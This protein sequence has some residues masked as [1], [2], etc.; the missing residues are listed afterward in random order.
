[1]PA[2]NFSVFVDQVENGLRAHPR[3]GVRC[4]TQTIRKMRKRPIKAGDT[5]YLYTKQRTRNSRK[6][7][8]VTCKS[9]DHIE[10][11]E[12]CY[13]NGD[14][15]GYWIAINGQ[16]LRCCDEQDALARADGFENREE[17]FEWF[18]THHGMPFDGQLIKW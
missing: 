3:P 18:G 17:F 14:V 12:I 11:D 10:M 15:M 7:G 13:S 8:E 6:L 4:K 2:L 5:L 16:E 1:M 9:A